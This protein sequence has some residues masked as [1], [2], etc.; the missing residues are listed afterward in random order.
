M[1][2][3]GADVE[4]H[5]GPVVAAD[6]GEELA[7]QLAANGR[8]AIERRCCRF[9]YV[10]G[11][12]REGH[13]AHAPAVSAG[14]STAVCTLCGRQVPVSMPHEMRAA[15]FRSCVG[16]QQVLILQRGRVLHHCRTEPVRDDLT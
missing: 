2:G 6:L 1:F 7:E 9:R 11:V 14:S 12:H 3:E 5:E 4:A 16:L 10:F 15:Y 13:A 8:D